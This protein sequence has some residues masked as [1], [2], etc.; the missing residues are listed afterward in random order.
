L[1]QIQEF[2]AIGNTVSSIT[3]EAVEVMA[4][5]EEAVPNQVRL[6]LLTDELKLLQSQL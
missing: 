6:Q 3:T 1:K 5:D 2:D 4:I